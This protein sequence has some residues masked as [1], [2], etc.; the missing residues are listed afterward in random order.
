MV[1]VSLPRREKN[2][3]V[4]VAS[5]ARCVGI[6]GNDTAA[7]T[8]PRTMATFSGEGDEVAGDPP[9]PSLVVLTFSGAGGPA[10]KKTAARLRAVTCAL[11]CTRDR[12]RSPTRFIQ[13]RLEVGQ[14]RLTPDASPIDLGAD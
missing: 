11:A 8:L 5:I 10:S 7:S 1:W 13:K 2:A 14:D 4:A 9:L 6:Y 3:V 12:R